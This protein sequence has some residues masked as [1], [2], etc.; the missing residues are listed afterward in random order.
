MSSELEIPK[1]ATCY[2]RSPDF[3]HDTVPE[4]LLSDHNLKTGTW[5]KL[6]VS[7]GEVRYF[8]AGSQSPDAIVHSN[9]T[10]TIP[11]QQMHFIQTSADAE[12]FIEFWRV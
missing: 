1:N 5:G 2:A 9:E 6:I 7:K 8:N 12:F 11:T 10:H 4:K 3:N